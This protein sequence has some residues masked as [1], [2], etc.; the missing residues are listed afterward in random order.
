M[1]FEA[2]QQADN[3]T[4][5]KYQGSGLGLAICTTLCQLMG[6]R[7][8]VHSRVGQGS[9]FRVV[10][11]PEATLP[12]IDLAAQYGSVHSPNHTPGQIDG[13]APAKDEADKLTLIIDDEPDGRLLLT[14][15]LEDLG[16]RT[17][18]A[19]SGMQ[20][21][22]VA[23]E[24]QPSLITLDLMMPRMDGWEVLKVLK[25][26]PDLWH[27][28]VVIVSVVAKE[29]PAIHFGMVDLL[30][31][32]VTRDGLLEVLQTKLHFAMPTPLTNSPAPDPG[33]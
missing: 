14:H 22:Q 18:T 3:S 17:T 16:F 10:L 24:L 11:S 30:E 33:R 26:D 13:A 23:R 9:T 7:L 31:K 8:E 6:Y 1:I 20:G 12:P 19:G 21:L 27:I 2:F 29:N 25:T 4:E 15:Y 32:P 5:R 28:P